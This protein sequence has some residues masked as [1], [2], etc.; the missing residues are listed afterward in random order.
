MKIATS[1]HPSWERLAAFD[2]GQLRAEEWPEIE[3]HVAVCDECCLRL[4]AVPQDALLARI[5]ESAAKPGATGSHGSP[6]T[7]KLL[8]SGTPPPEAPSWPADQEIP[9]ELANHS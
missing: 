5:R 1:S 8:G 4:E 2:L 7:W 6:D 9:P 3:R